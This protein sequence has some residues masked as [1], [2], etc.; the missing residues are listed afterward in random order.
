MN[1][2]IEIALRVASLDYLGVVAA[3][4]RKDAV[5][6]QLK[7]DTIDQMIKEIQ[8]EEQKDSEETD[9]K[10]KK[11]L[12]VIFLLNSRFIFFLCILQQ[13]QVGV[14]TIYNMCYLFF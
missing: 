11:V 1:K 9:T 10:K 6:S 8:E 3:R 5:T 4:L 13:F 2:S 14:T 7:V 12:I